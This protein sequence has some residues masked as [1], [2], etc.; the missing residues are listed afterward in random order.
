MPV[1]RLEPYGLVILIGLLIVLP[2]LGPL[3]VDL[4]RFSDGTDTNGHGYVTHP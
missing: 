1:A 4:S 3:V 2:L